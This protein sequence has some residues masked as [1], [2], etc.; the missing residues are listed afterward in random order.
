[1]KH[2]Q[3]YDGPSPIFLAMMAILL[4]WLFGFKLLFF[5]P[6]LFLFGAFRWGTCGAHHWNDDD[7]YEW[8]DWSGDKPKRKGKPE[9]DET[10][11]IDDMDDVTYL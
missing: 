3:H 2:A 9:R 11:V 10:I 4:F 1:M 6:L 7:N 5:L 8:S